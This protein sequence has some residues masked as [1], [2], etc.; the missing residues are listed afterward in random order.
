MFQTC[1]LVL[2]YNRDFY[3]LE[4]IALK[5]AALSY[6]TG[7]VVSPFFWQVVRLKLREVPSE[8]FCKD[9]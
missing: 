5:Q 2:N 7:E 4:K 3:D 8:I 9:N 6:V 1:K